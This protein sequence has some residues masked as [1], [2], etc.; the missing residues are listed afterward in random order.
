MAKPPE[1]VYDDRRRRPV[2]LDL[3]RTGRGL[4]AMLYGGLASLISLVITFWTLPQISSDGRLPIFRLVVLLAV[5]S[6]LMRWVLAGVAVLIGSLGVLIG[7]LLSQFGVVYLAITVDPGVD[8]HGGVEALEPGM[9]DVGERTGQGDRIRPG[10][11]QFLGEVGVA[12]GPGE[13]PLQCGLR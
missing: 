2:W 6:V 5:F 1:Q 10:L 4:Q 9:Q 12:L 3:R 7:G 11:Q 13:H 8:L